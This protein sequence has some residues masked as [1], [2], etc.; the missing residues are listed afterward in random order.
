[1]RVLEYPLIGAVLAGLQFQCGCQLPL[2]GVRPGTSNY[3]GG[4]R[5]PGALHS[6]LICLSHTLDPEPWSVSARAARRHRGAETWSKAHFTLA[7]GLVGGPLAESHSAR[8]WVPT[9]FGMHTGCDFAK[10]ISKQ[11]SHRSWRY[12]AGACS[13]SLGREERVASVRELRNKDGRRAGSGTQ[14]QP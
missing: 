4:A 7:A 5:G 3:T 10:D 8:H 1:M 11:K 12:R 9:R 2:P 13:A 14:D 6:E